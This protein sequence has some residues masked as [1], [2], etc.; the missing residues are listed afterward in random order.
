MQPSFLSPLVDQLKEFGQV[1]ALAMLQHL[2]TSYRAIDEIDSKKNSVKMMGPYD[3]TE[4][5]AQLIKQLEKGIE[6]ARSVR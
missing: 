6:S 5:L 4:H 3:P 1:S 2:F